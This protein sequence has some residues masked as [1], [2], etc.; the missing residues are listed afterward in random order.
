MQAYLSKYTSKG[1]KSK[2]KSRNVVIDDD[3]IQDAPDREINS[4]F[5]G[6]KRV[7]G[8][9]G[10]EKTRTDEATEATEAKD[11]N[12]TVT[13]NH[14]PQQQTVY[15]DL[16]GKVIDINQIK[17]S[18]KSNPIDQPLDNIVLN[19]PSS[20]FDKKSVGTFTAGRDDKQYNEQLKSRTNVEDP[21]R[22]KLINHDRLSYNK[23]INIPN[24]FN[25]KAGILWD[26]IDRSNGFEKLVMKK[27]DSV[28]YEKKQV[29]DYDLED[30]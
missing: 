7:G 27:R 1:K 9:D 25:L 11:N 4:N 22:G 19:K 24:R 26:G 15:R 10:N 18:K 16:S 6:F 29:E 5:K 17:P 8:D 3:S 14:T 13:T 23:G 28:K 2:N 20:E 21:M 30:I 12:N